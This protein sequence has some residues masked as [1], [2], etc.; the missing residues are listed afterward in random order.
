M[1][2]C[3]RFVQQCKLHCPWS[4]IV[5]RCFALP[6]LKIGGV[7]YSTS[8]IYSYWVHK[9]MY[10]VQHRLQNNELHVFHTVELI[11]HFHFHVQVDFKV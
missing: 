9:I 7:L 4:Q 6:A 5:Y 1:F 3:V 11:V 2:L 8:K 10:T